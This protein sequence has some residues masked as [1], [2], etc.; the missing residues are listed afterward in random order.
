MTDARL[1]PGGTRTVLAED[2][3]RRLDEAIA[4]LNGMTVSATIEPP[5]EDRLETALDHLYAAA[6]ILRHGDEAL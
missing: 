3:L 2:L 4:I 1:R 6:S 5:I